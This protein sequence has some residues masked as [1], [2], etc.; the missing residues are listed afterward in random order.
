MTAEECAWLVEADASYEELINP[1]T[2]ASLVAI[3]FAKYHVKKALQAAC[4]KAVLGKQGAFGVYW[5]RGDLL[6]DEESVINSYPLTEI[7]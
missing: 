5:N 4:K 2:F 6:L 7:K 3:K 1:K